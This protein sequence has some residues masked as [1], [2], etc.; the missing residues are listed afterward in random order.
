VCVPQAER[1]R[2]SRA[3]A[4][5]LHSAQ[6]KLLH[7][8]LRRQVLAGEPMIPSTTMSNTATATAGRDLFALPPLPPEA[9][10]ALHD[11]DESTDAEHALGEDGEE[12][13]PLDDTDEEE[14]QQEQQEQQEQEEDSRVQPISPG[15]LRQ[16]HRGPRADAQVLKTDTQSLQ[17]AYDELLAQAL[18][19]E[20]DPESEEGAVRGFS[21][22]AAADPIR[23]EPAV[24]A[25]SA[26][27]AGTKYTL[28]PDQ[29]DLFSPEFEALPLEIQYEIIVDRKERAKV[30]T[31]RHQVIDRTQ[32][33]GSFS[34]Q[35]VRPGALA[36]DMRERTAGK[37]VMQCGGNA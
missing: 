9:E 8:I 25:T 27:H 1:R 17:V 2:R 10:A 34:S 3:G 20:S 33:S 18:A 13:E 32:A 6:A 15:R 28:N 36:F 24:A 23:V 30:K 21:H 35:Q 22:P 19:F 29:V 5:Q 14:Q 16:H 37:R 11:S 26:V 4:E 12:E 7:N 31:R